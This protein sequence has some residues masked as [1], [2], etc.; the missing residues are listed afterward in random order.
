MMNTRASGILLHV[1]SLPSLYG[2]GDL[3]PGAFRFV[4]FLKK[5]GQRYWQIL[6][7]N[8]T[9]LA[10]GNSPYSSSSA[11][12]GNILLTSPDL[13]CQEGFVSQREIKDTSCFS[14]GQVDY[15]YVAAYKKDLLF[16][17]YQNSKKKVLR[18]KRFLTF[19]K[20]NQYWIEDY[21]LFV[22]LK[23]H[24]QGRTWNQWPKEI[25]QRQP[26]AIKTYRERFKEHIDQEIFFQYLF[27]KQWSSLKEYC[28][29]QGICII[30]DLP[31]YVQHDSADVWANPGIFKLDEQG[32][33]LGLAGVPP[34][35][36]SETGQLW[37][38]PVYRWEALSASRYHW[39]KQR[40][41]QNFK[42]F[43]I[44]RL[45]HF[46]GFVAYWEIPQGEKTAVNGQW[47]GA[48]TVDFFD[49]MKATFRNFSIIAEDLGV[50][51]PEVEEIIQRYQFPG[52]KVLMF[53]F[54]GKED[55]PYLPEN[56]VKNC[57]VYPGTHDNNTVQ[58]W[59]KEE[60][61]EETKNHIEK[62][63]TEPI[64]PREI[65]WQILIMAM[66]SIADTV[67]FAM[68]DALGLDQSHRMNLPSTTQRNWQW[69]VL[70][71]QLDSQMAKTLLE[72]TRSSDRL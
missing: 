58:G 8:P 35:Y 32:C 41:Q 15:S 10:T 54:D 17:A 60:V 53:A 51:T 68:Q 22:V 33:S 44:V 2:I 18:D 64:V 16:R 61:S 66:R 21:A 39:W 62:A 36:F 6:P 28:N 45:D 14:P 56:H 47:V 57:V 3:G 40:F 1:T 69:R 29:K 48:P 49:E 52:M 13:L 9:D 38:N 11:F 34:D 65:H 37:G 72:L 26:A 7:L 5:S 70:E 42:Y 55:N 4:D 20:N 31:F 24:Y 25:A 19:R 30:G 71:E 12:A 43:D 46:R 59:F 67:I 63:L 50:I 23:N 27:L